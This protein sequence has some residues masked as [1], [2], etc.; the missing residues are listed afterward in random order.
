MM[1]KLGRDRTCY[2]Q[3]HTEALQPVLKDRLDDV[4]AKEGGCFHV[5]LFVSSLAKANRKVRSHFYF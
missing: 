1:S 2:E 5:A 3:D 4:L